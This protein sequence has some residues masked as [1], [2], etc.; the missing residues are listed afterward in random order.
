MTNGETKLMKQVIMTADGMSAKVLRSINAYCASTITTVM[1]SGCELVPFE[2][3]SS[4]RQGCALSHYLNIID[5]PHGQAFQGFP[6]VQFGTKVYVSDLLYA[7]DLL[8]LSNCNREMH[9][10]LEPINHIDASKTKVMSAL[11][12]SGPRQAILL[13]NE[14]F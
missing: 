7:D 13:A 14:P 4:V 12:T 3:R 2:M 9:G 5:P 6:C 8:F 1:T 10:L 11:L